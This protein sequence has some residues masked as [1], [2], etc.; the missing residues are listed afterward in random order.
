MSRPPRPRG[1]RAAR[2]CDDR[3]LPRHAAAEERVPARHPLCRQA[4]SS[5]R[6]TATA[7]RDDPGSA[8][9]FPAGA[10]DLLGDGRGGQR[11]APARGRPG[12]GRGRQAPLPVGRARRRRHAGARRPLPDAGGAPRRGPRDRLTQGDQASTR[13]PPRRDARVRP[14]ERDRARRAGPAPGGPRSA[15]AARATRPRVPRVPDRRGP[16]APGAPLPRRARALG[17]LGRPRCAR[18]GRRRR[19]T[20]PSPSRCATSAGNATEAPARG[21]QR[22]GGT[23]RQP[24]CRFARFTLSGPALRRA[25]RRAWRGC[26]VGPF[27]RSFDFVLSRLGKPRPVVS[28]RR[29]GGSFRVRVPRRTRTGVY[30]VRVRAGRRHAVWPLAVAGL[31]QKNGS[32]GRPRPLVVLPALSWLGR[33]RVDDDHDGFADSLPGR[34]PG[35]ARHASS[36]GG[37]LPAGASLGGVAAAAVPRPRRADVRPHHRPVAG[38]RRRPGARQRHRGGVRGQRALW[39]PPEL[40]QRLRALRGRRRPARVLRRGRVPARRAISAATRSAPPRAPARPTCSASAPRC[41]APAR[42]RSASSRTT[43]A[44]STGS[45]A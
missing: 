31:P 42:R 16:P 19:A 8:S 7:T 34:S 3:G 22:A 11:G 43:W 5:S 36:A 38:P 12:A 2:G 27:D 13:R 18:A 41:C 40:L 44:C 45:P 6:P 24:A 15:T 17:G 32:A 37:A 14:P 1:V 10:G 23:A 20:T 28:G 25:G 9:T 33:E 21:A 29:I 30:V 26:E 4:A 35:P 39:L